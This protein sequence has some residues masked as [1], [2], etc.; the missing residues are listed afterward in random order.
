MYFIK[1]IDN[2]PVDGDGGRDRLVDGDGETFVSL[3][4]F[5]V[6]DLVLG[7][8]GGSEVDQGIISNLRIGNFQFGLACRNGSGADRGVPF[9]CAQGR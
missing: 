1:L 8:G 9:D 5:E 6:E 3:F 4:G 7:G 2:P